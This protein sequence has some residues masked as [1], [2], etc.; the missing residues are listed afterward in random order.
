MV[1]DVIDPRYV[2]LCDMLALHHARVMLTPPPQAFNHPTLHAQW[3][4]ALLEQKT[5]SLLQDEE[6]DD[7]D[8][9]TL[10]PFSQENPGR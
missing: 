7:S 10:I 8:T 9:P 5:S 4:A 3:F 6:W 2:E 1:L